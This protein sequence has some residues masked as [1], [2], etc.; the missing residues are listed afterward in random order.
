MKGLCEK[1]FC[2]QNHVCSAGEY[3]L[4]I[5]VRRLQHCRG[6]CDFALV[7][8]GELY[9]RAAQHNED[10][11]LDQQTP[12]LIYTKRGL[13]VPLNYY[14]VGEVLWRDAPGLLELAS[15]SLQGARQDKAAKNAASG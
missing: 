8:S 14:L 5:S 4:P 11:F 9:L 15:Q 7:S 6:R 10:F 13:P 12:K 2:R 1:G 3:S